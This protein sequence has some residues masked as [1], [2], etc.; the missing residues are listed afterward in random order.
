MEGVS[1]RVAL[2]ISSIFVLFGVVLFNPAAYAGCDWSGTTAG[3]VSSVG[4]RPVVLEKATSRML[5]NRSWRDDVRFPVGSLLARDTLTL[6]ARLC[7][8]LYEL[9]GSFLDVHYI[10]PMNA[11][12]HGA[13]FLIPGSAQGVAMLVEFPSGAM[14]AGGMLIG[15]STERVRPGGQLLLNRTGIPPI[16]VRLSLVKTGSFSSTSA[17]SVVAFADGLGLVR[18]F[19]AGRNDVIAIEENQLVLSS[20]FNAAPPGGKP[21]LANA[22]APS[23]RAE[24]IA[25]AGGRVGNT[26]A[27]VRM[28]PVANGEF[29]G[30]GAIEVAQHH[31]P[32]LFT[33]DGSL[34]S[35]VS[36]S[37][38]STFPFNNGADGVGMPAANSDVGI[39]LLLNDS[40]VSFGTASVSLPWVAVSYDTQ[41]RAFKDPDSGTLYTA[42]GHYCR[43]DCG[44]D[45]SNASWVDGGAASGSNRGLGGTSLTLKYYQTTANRPAPQHFSVP[46]TVSLDV[47]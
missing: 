33:C 24:E 38:D 9:S 31:G 28:V 25:S 11:K 2:R 46:F 5:V 26:L 47:H 7:G 12:P 15:T 35:A 21:V 43:A 44:D 42:H 29:S 10:A 8:G 27:T 34:S 39:Q 4:A 6:G 20:L 36:V 45:M 14:S 13:G 17:A 3:I 41:G 40:P 19:A 16:S 30:P 23:C 22:R 18:Y 32:L 1:F 37:F